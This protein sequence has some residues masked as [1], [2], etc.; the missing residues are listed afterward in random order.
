MLFRRRHCD[1]V[2]G[3]DVGCEESRVTLRPARARRGHRSRGPLHRVDHWADVAARVRGD[4]LSEA[5][6]R[7]GRGILREAAITRKELHVRAA[8]FHGLVCRNAPEYSQGSGAVW[9]A[10]RHLRSCKGQPVLAGGRRRLRGPVEP[11]TRKPRSSYRDPQGEIVASVGIWSPV[12][13]QYAT[14]MRVP[15]R[16]CRDSTCRQ[17]VAG[18]LIQPGISDGAT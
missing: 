8:P 10:R 5:S 3:C 16:S 1:H 15:F 14:L 2:R 17:R 11:R 9:R 7:R 6:R 18:E 13:R 4:P 12:T